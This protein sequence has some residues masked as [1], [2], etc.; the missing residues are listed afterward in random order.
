MAPKLHTFQ[1]RAW[2]DG[3]EGLAAR[4]R[5][6]RIESSRQVLHLNAELLDLIQLLSQEAID[7]PVGAEPCHFLIVNP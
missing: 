3:L 4:E 6:C 7:V 1:Q 5:V 2:R